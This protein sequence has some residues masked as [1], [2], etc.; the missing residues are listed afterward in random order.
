MLCVQLLGLAKE[1]VYVGRGVASCQG[2]SEGCAGFGTS[3]IITM[4]VVIVY[5]SYSE[6]VNYSM[7]YI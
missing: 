6:N 5:Y 3:I 1:C 2:V 7:M 4:I